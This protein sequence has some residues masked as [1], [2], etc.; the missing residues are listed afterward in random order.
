ML[1]NCFTASTSKKQKLDNTAA[2]GISSGGGNDKV[3]ASDK[4]TETDVS[5][6]I[7]LGHKREDVIAEL[8]K[9]NGDKQKATAALIA[10]SLKL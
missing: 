8:R 1:N 5:D 9:N 4:F 3:L 2:G 10:K 7:K 6:L